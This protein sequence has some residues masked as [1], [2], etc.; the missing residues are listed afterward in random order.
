M[1]RTAL[2]CR[3]NLHLP[4]MEVHHPRVGGVMETTGQTPA[5]KKKNVG[6]Q[7]MYTLWI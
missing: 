6:K 7:A 3:V 4:E 1:F 5:P 2:L